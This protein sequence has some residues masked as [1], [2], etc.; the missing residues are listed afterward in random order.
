MVLAFGPVACSSVY[1]FTHHLS[2]PR[3]V[4]QCHE[5]PQ[6]TCRHSGVPL[7]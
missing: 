6:V 7:P 2:P 5:E 4:R 1:T 3:G